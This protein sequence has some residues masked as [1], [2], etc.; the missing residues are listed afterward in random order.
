MYAERTWIGSAHPVLHANGLIKEIGHNIY[1]YVGGCAQTASAETIVS[2][3]THRWSSA[4]AEGGDIAYVRQDEVA[5]E[6]DAAASKKMY[7]WS[8]GV[9]EGGRLAPDWEG[10]PRAAAAVP[11][12][13]R[14][15]CLRFLRCSSAIE[16]LALP[17]MV[18]APAHAVYPLSSMLPCE[19]RRWRTL[20]GC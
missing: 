15:L 1:V 7:L 9:A 2:D 8:S 16:T 18:T 6:G 5:S 10:W 19:G 3:R 17:G 20:A 4:V 13:A 14:L 12:A 11:C